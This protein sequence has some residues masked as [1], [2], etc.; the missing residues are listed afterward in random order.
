MSTDT[1]PERPPL[2]DER[3]AEISED[4]EIEANLDNASGQQGAHTGWA[5]VGELL[6]ELDRLR[7]RLTLAEAH[8]GRLER[9]VSGLHSVE[10]MPI[11]GPR[12]W[13][14]ECSCDE[15]LPLGDDEPEPGLSA[16]LAA[17]SVHGEEVL[18]TLR[19]AVAHP[20]TESTRNGPIAWPAEDVRPLIVTSDRGMDFLD[21]IESWTTIREATE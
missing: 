11:R 14:V 1:S 16:I 12:G 17:C 7:E 2:S 15:Q 8:V 6:A 10:I 4:H 3:L 21:T 19:R 20:P 18:T 5:A 9:E 13:W